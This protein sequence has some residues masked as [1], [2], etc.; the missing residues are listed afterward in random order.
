MKGEE[1]AGPRCGAGGARG[2]PGRAG[3][4]RP[5]PGR[6]PGAA[7]VPA[8]GPFASGA[9]DPRAARAAP[10]SRARWPRGLRRPGASGETLPEKGTVR[11]HLSSP[12]PGTGLSGREKKK[13]KLAGAAG[14]PIP[15]RC[16]AT[17]GE[18]RATPGFARPRA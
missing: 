18:D 6:I 1:R 16:A 17:D 13:K 12:T 3:S 7:A 15:A 5:G 2:R 8:R 14:L 11:G 10:G 4:P 9:P